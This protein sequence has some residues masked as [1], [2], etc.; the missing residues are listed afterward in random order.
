MARIF[1]T[2]RSATAR[3]NCPGC[4]PARPPASCSTSTPMRTV[5]P[6]SGTPAGSDWR[7][8]CRSGSP[9]PIV[10]ARRETGS[11]SRTPTA[12]RCGGRARGCGNLGSWQSRPVGAD[13]LCGDQRVDTRN[14]QDNDRDQTISYAL[15]DVHLRLPRGLP[16]LVALFFE[17]GLARAS[18]GQA[19]LGVGPGPPPLPRGRGLRR[20]WKVGWAE[21]GMQ[22]ST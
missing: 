3:R 18:G 19:G 17:L 8:S 22:G 6:C 12:Q 2:C 7:A 1:D 4:W 14:Y 9:R 21:D 16:R 11:R 13:R 5:P 15:E 20:G 10:R